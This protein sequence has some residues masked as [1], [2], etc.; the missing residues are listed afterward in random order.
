[1]TRTS[2][3]AF[4]VVMSEATKYRHARRVRPVAVGHTRRSSTAR[5]GPCLRY[6]PRSSPMCSIPRFG[7]P[8]CITDVI[9]LAPSLLPWC[10]RDVG[11]ARTGLRVTRDVGF[12]PRRA[13]HPECRVLDR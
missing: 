11:C 10:G 4:E 6:P 1:M 5:G 12:L 9:E 3:M 7:R 13:H 8:A 2:V